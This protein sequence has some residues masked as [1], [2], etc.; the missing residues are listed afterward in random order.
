MKEKQTIC[1]TCMDCD[2][3]FN[4]GWIHPNAKRHHK[5]TGHTVIVNW[6]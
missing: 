1:G 2:K 6:M 3:T 4:T 5:A